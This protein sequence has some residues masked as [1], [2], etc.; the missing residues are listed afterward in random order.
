MEQKYTYSNGD[1]AVG[2]IECR[3][4]Q[5]ADIKIKKID[6]DSKT[7]SIDQ[8]ANGTSKDQ[9]KCR[10]QPGVLRRCFF[11]KIKN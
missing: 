3:P 8:V 4:M 2:D 1:R 7:N 9:C 5:V 6:N 11:I 10:S